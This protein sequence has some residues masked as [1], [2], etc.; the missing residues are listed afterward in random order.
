MYCLILIKDKFSWQKFC[1]KTNVEVKTRLA[2][3]KGIAEYAEHTLEEC[4]F[5]LKISFETSSVCSRKNYCN[6]Y[7]AE[8]KRRS[9]AENRMNLHSLTFILRCR[10]YITLHYAYIR[11]K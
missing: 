1:L 2:E 9:A 11:L 6:V 10:R 8:I 5:L 3:L 4:L 7:G